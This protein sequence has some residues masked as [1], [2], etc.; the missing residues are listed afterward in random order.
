MA[1]Q[2]TPKGVCSRQITFD[3]DDEGRV[4]NVQFHGGCHGNTQGIAALCEGMPADEVISRLKGIRCGM[5]PSSCPAEL[6]KA[7]EEVW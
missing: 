3:L 2:Y 6:A 7:V 5:K 4:H 1:H